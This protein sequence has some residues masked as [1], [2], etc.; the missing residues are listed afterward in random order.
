MGR[1]ALICVGVLLVCLVIGCGGGGGPNPPPNNAGQIT[2]R[3]AGAN[4]APQYTI[5]VDGQPVTARPNASGD[6]TVPN[7]PPGNHTIGFVGPGG[8]QGAYRA[9]VVRRGQSTAIGD[10]APTLGGQIAGIVTKVLQDGTI[11]AVKGVEVIATSA[12]NWVEPQPGDNEP[13]GV[14]RTGDPDQ[15][16]ISA[17]TN[18]NGS[19]LMEAVPSGSYDVTVVVPGYDPQIQ[20][21]WV[22][23]GSTAVAD[24]R[25]YPAPEQGVGTVEGLVTGEGAPIEGAHITLT[26][27]SP[28]PVPV[29]ML[30]VEKWLQTRPGGGGGMPCADGAC[31]PPWIEIQVFNT[32]TDAL[33]HYS[34]NVPIGT[35]F[36][37]CWAD[38]WDWQG[39]D[40]TIEKNQTTTVDFDLTKWTDPGDPGDPTDPPK[41]DNS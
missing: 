24:F 3:L 35:H 26:T 18:A 15:I 13:I 9:V 33:G 7:V 1:V 29:P 2:G 39:Q 23:A 11:E 41:P 37:E 14:G 25:V 6:F 19:Y 8:M 27:G 36:I 34:L 31:P 21:V 30:G 5:T 16:V 10:V 12:I 20:Y 4:N 32:L 38:G 28:W 40:V 22:D 17:F